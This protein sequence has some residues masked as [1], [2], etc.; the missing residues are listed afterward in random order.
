[1]AVPN[2]A[3]TST[4]WP[5][6]RLGDVCDESTTVNPSLE[7][8]KLFD[9]VDISSISSEQLQIIE[10]QKILGKDA[11]SR[12]RKRIFYGDVIFATVRPTLKRIALVPSELDGE[13]CSTGFVV[14]R[15][16][17]TLNKYYLFYYLQSDIFMKN[18]ESLQKG[19]SYP[20]VTDGDVKSQHIPLPPLAEQERIVARLDAAFADIAEAT[21]AAKA[22]LRNARAL[23]DSYLDQVFS[24]RGEGW[25]ERRLGDVGEIFDGPHATPKTIGSGPIFLGISALKDG[26]IDLSETRHI[27]E[28]DFSQWTRRIV[29]KAGDFVFS[30]ETRLGQAAIIPEGLRCCL[31]RRMG[32]IRF[33]KSIIDVSFF[34]YL[35]ISPKGKEYLDTKVV[36]GATV[37]RYSIRDF[38]DFSFTIPD[39]TTQRE[40]TQKTKVVK[41]HTK[42]LID[43]YVR[44]LAALAELRQALLAEVFGEG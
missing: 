35:Y 10:P 7:L 41:S 3:H 33:D 38:P 20:A 32:L 31:G 37:D 17:N 13:V 16:K 27:S 15:A 24:T 39:L 28:E 29:P 23:F 40:I 43:C 6:V 5:L 34:T 1:M 19:A 25:V 21:A 9:Y 26:D 2:H 36:S 30:Y 22:N 18:M 44:K 42:S 14:L 12:A 8:Q 11:P 4:R